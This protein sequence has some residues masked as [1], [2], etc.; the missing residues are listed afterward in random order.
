MYKAALAKKVKTAVVH[1]LS[2]E[3]EGQSGHDEDGDGLDALVKLASLDDK[4]NPGHFQR[5]AP[6]APAVAAAAVASPGP[7]EGLLEVNRPVVLLGQDAAASTSMGS[8]SLQS[9]IKV[10]TWS[11]EKSIGEDQVG[12]PHLCVWISCRKQPDEALRK[13]RLDLVQQSCPQVVV[14]VQIST[15]MTFHSR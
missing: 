15:L 1:I 4:T 11:R 10:R 14:V 6:P 2:P 8:S 12:S 3:A 5:A 7:T 13:S 9:R